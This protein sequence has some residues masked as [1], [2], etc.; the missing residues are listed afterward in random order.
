MT[1]E[2]FI[3][4]Y[5]HYRWLIKTPLS[6]PLRRLECP[7]CKTEGF[8]IKTGEE[9]IIIKQQEIDM[10]C[11]NCKYSE[12]ENDRCYCKKKCTIIKKYEKKQQNGKVS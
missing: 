12:I 10:S 6:R 2:E 1:Y 8:I 11:R 4:M 3:C 5:C 7:K 9:P